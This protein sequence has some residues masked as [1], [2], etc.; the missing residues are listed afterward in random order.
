M[1]ITNV[2]RKFLENMFT[3]GEGSFMI[4]SLSKNVFPKELAFPEGAVTTSYTAYDADTDEEFIIDSDTYDK[5][6]VDTRCVFSSTSYSGIGYPSNTSYTGSGYTGFSVSGYSK[7]LEFPVSISNYRFTSR[8]LT[9]LFVP[10]KWTALNDNKGFVISPVY[11]GDNNN[12]TTSSLPDACAPVRGLLYSGF[13]NTQTNLSGITSVTCTCQNVGST[14]KT[15]SKIMLLS[16]TGSYSSIGGTTEYA[17][18]SGFG[19]L[20]TNGEAD[21][22]SWVTHTSPA[23][24]YSS[25][26]LPILY[27]DDNNTMHLLKATNKSYYLTAGVLAYALRRNLHLSAIDLDTT[28]R[29]YEY[30]CF[31]VMAPMIIEDLDAPITLAAGES[32]TIKFNLDLSNR[33]TWMRSYR[34]DFDEGLYYYTTSITGEYKKPE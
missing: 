31:G 18:Y 30:S 9:P 25:V 10:E 22:T 29:T 27:K 5:L 23:S 1:A 6:Y 21:P 14:D 32:C 33:E 34:S 26:T 3:S 11:H 24:P 4:M 8:S 2:F 19:Y 13:I 17:P 20:Y 28:S 7:Y 16:T 12:P 15:F